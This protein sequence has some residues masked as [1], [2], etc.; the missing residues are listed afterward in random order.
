M[1]RQHI[2]I[3]KRGLGQIWK[4]SQCCIWA[5][6]PRPPKKNLIELQC[7][8]SLMLQ[9]LHDPYCKKKRGGG[10]KARWFHGRSNISNWQKI[11]NF[12]KPENKNTLRQ[13]S[14]SSVIWP[15]RWNN[16]NWK[17]ADIFFCWKVRNKC[18]MRI[19]QLHTS[20][21][22]LKRLAWKTSWLI[23]GR[24]KMTKGYCHLHCARRVKQLLFRQRDSL[25][26]MIIMSVFM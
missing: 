1:S 19:N 2:S 22:P 8:R 9:A 11:K 24:K 20:K 13:R 14:L 26:L 5:T 23:T 10:G 3:Y 21:P 25:W 12:S 17:M 18:L 6:L 4:K 7:E 16:L 15:R